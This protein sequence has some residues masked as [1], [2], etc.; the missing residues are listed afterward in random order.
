M[1]NRGRPIRSGPGSRI[2]LP[3]LIR[4]SGAPR[5]VVGPGLSYLEA[6]D[7]DACGK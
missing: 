1:S 5:A 7:R 6:V 4:R 3:L 2:D